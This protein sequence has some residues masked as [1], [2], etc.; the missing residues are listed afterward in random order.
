MML[1]YL[2]VREVTFTIVAR[3]YI[4]CML[5]SFVGRGCK[6]MEGIIGG[7]HY[8]NI[9]IIFISLCDGEGLSS[10]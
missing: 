3:S 1:T 9:M 2:L 6:F 8:N 5:A 7:D 10:H 4:L